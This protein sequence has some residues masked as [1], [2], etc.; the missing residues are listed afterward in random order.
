[1]DPTITQKNDNGVKYMTLPDGRRLSYCT[2]GSSSP[3]HHVFYF[4]SY[5]GSRLE[6]TLLHEAATSHNIQLIC[7]DRPGMGS[8]TFLPQRRILDW[9]LDV[10]ALADH[11]TITR[12]ACIGTSGGGPFALACYHKIPRTR[13]K[14]AAIASGIWPTS[15]GTQGMLLESR[16]ML[17]IAPWVPSLVAAGLEYGVGRAA[18][19]VEH[20][21]AYAATIA[22]SFESR[23]EVDRKVWQQNIGGFKDVLLTNLREALKAGATGSAHEAK[24]Y[25]SDWGFALQDVKVEEN[26]LAIWHGGLDQNVPLP[27]AEKAIALMPGCNLELFPDEGHVSLIAGRT[28]SFVKRVKDMLQS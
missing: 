11:L 16:V 15:L 25:G 21:E 9:P 20:P 13:L 8:S 12:F 26:T 22:K 23:P 5:P 3:S 6:G 28:S 19:D 4:H 17:F 1:M 14:A 24:L 2:Y 7:P 18:R 27:M 10:L